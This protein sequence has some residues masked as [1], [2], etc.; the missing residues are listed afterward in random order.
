MTISRRGLLQ[1]AGAAAILAAGPARAAGQQLKF[2]YQRSSTLLTILKEHHVLEGK[3]GPKGFEPAWYL[4][5]EVLAPMTAGAVDFHADVA[6]AVPI[7]TQAAGAKL[8][9][10]A[11]EAPSPQAEAII[12]HADS[13]IKTVGD[14]KGKTVGVRRGSGA[15][16]VLAAALK[17]AGLS[18]GDITPAYLAPTDA[19]PA[20]QQRSI[21]AWAIWDPFL[22]IT[23]SRTAT[24][25]LADATGLSGYQRYYLVNDDFVAAHPDVVQIVFDALVQTGKWVKANPKE[26]AAFLSP[27][28][29]NVPVEVVETVNSRRTYQVLPVAKS[30]LGDQQRIADTF[31][32]FRLIPKAIDATSVKLWRPRS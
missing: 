5:N 17:R 10:Y 20:F 16:F 21:D 19:G 29:G 12:V 7:F 24:R 9:I 32:E 1:G 26:A 4:F 31:Y 27:I 3:L 6:D 25:K 22:A 14:L 30:D 13:P 28:W 23:E 2:S 18:F 11:R 8:T 15:H